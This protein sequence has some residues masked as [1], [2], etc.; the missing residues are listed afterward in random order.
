[1][2]LTIDVE[3]PQKDSLERLAKARGVSVASLVRK[4]LDAYLRRQRK[5]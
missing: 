5:V 1:M 4:A 2:S 3:K